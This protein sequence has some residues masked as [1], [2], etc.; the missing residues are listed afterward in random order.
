[1][2]TEDITR[3]RTP[4]GGQRGP[5]R[6]SAQACG[7]CEYVTF[8]YQELQNHLAQ[9]GHKKPGLLRRAK[10]TSI[11]LSLFIAL[12]I[13][14]AILFGAVMAAIIWSAKILVFVGIPALLIYTWWIRRD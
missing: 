10:R 3:A 1:M 5:I 4:R 13:G 9:T 2:E 14:G 7:D 6:P 12:I 8:I 11:E